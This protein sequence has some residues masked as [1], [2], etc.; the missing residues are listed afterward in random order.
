MKLAYV[1]GAAAVGL[2]ATYALVGRSPVSQ[3]ADHKDSDALAM[4]ANHAADINDVYV[5]PNSDASKINLVMTVA[6]IAAAG[7]TFGTSILYSFH[8][9]ALDATGMNP[10]AETLITCKF[11]SN[12]SVECWVGA[13]EYVAGDPSATTGLVST[14]S[15]VK[16]FA[17][18]RADPFFFN[19]HGFAHIA[20]LVAA[21]GL[22]A[23]GSDGKGCTNLGAN[24]PVFAGALAKDTD[25][26]TAGTDT[27]AGAKTLAIVIQLDKT[28]LTAT[29][30]PILSVWA[31]TN[32][33][34]A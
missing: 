9:N 31:S 4:A 25:G 8:V 6:P 2:A 13:S 19:L 22:P 5:W 28:L 17:G 26:V 20:G 14:D 32:Q 34:G 18:L 16:I 24:G 15:K 7:D 11:A 29:G 12:T 27:F 3:A 10:A 1:A 30:K 33:P 21:A 23:T